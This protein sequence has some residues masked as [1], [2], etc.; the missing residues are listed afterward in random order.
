MSFIICEMDHRRPVMQTIAD[1]EHV[2]AQILDRAARTATWLRSF[3][4]DPMMLLRKL[5]LET[6]GHDPL[7]GAPLNVVE[8][9][10]RPSPFWSR[11]AQSRS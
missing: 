3:D 4:A 2:H 7:T 6:V 9:L 11:F 10:N 8:Q 1:A 5:R